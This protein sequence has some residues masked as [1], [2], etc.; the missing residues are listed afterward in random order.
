MQSTTYVHPNLVAFWNLLAY[1]K[2]LVKT[3]LLL[4]ILISIPAYLVSRPEMFVEQ[5]A[6]ITGIEFSRAK[7]MRYSDSL[8]IN[9][10]FIYKNKVFNRW[11][12][13]YLPL[14]YPDEKVGEYVA[15]WRHMHL[16]DS[17]IKIKVNEWRPRYSYLSKLNEFKVGSGPS[18]WDFYIYFFVYY[19]LF[20]MTVLIFISMT[21]KYFFM[22]DKDDE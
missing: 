2:W 12:S 20:P 6:T 15:N 21:I 7:N 19:W 22:Q 10:Q 8:I 1:P 18:F 4:L 17:D 11:G 13:H 3:A 16:I 14:G 5:N 9:Y